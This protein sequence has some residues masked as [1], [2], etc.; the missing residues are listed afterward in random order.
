MVF[1]RRSGFCIGRS[2]M[3]FSNQIVL[4]VFKEIV[5]KS[6][7]CSLIR[8]RC[9]SLSGILAGRY[10]TGHSIFSKSF[11]GLCSQKALMT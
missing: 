3:L 7:I 10:R 8:L 6:I 11:D 2:W 5:A 4:K 9:G 1:E